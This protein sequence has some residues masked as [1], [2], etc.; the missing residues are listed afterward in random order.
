MEYSVENEEGKENLWNQVS[1]ALDSNDED[2]VIALSK[3]LS[4]AGDPRGS[5]TLGY[6]FQNKAIRLSDE[7]PSQSRENFIAAAHWYNRALSQGGNYLSH[8]ALAQ[9]YYFG[10]GGKYDFKLAYE[11]L[12]H[13]VEYQPVAKIMM[14]ELLFLGLG[15]PK[16]VATAR[17]LFAVAAAIGYPAAIVGLSRIERA[18]KHYVRAIFYFFRALRVAIKLVF[19]DKYHPLLT[20]VGKRWHSFRLDWYEKMGSPLSH[21]NDHSAVRS[22]RPPRDS[23]S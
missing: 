18:E 9:Y 15:T 12:K 5:Y 1:L 2:R 10:S 6:V 17:T 16:D 21:P 3:E 7:S 13:S 19:E 22:K 8:H 11:H 14:A 20:G 23:H 4:E